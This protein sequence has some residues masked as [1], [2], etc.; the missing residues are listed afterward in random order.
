MPESL[1]IHQPVFINTIG[2]SAGALIFGFLL[3]LLLR[4]GRAPKFGLPAL[5]ALLALLWNAGSLVVL[6]STASGPGDPQAATALSFAALSMMPAV[7]LALSLG[8][9]GVIFQRI[10]WAVSAVA[11]GLHLAEAVLHSP[12][13]H[14]GA[15]LLIAAAFALLSVGAAVTGQDRRTRLLSRILTPMALLVFASSFVHFGESDGGHA[16]SEEIALHH[17]GIP[18]ALFIVLQQDYRF[19]LLDAFTRS[20]A[21][22]GLASAF[23]FAALEV[24]SRFG[25]LIQ[26]SRSPLIGGFA[27]VAACG[28]LVLFAW[29]RSALQL[30]LTARVFRRPVLEDAV[31]R[32]VSQVAPS[33]MELLESLAAVIAEH[34]G[35]GRFEIRPTSGSEWYFP[36]PVGRRRREGIPEWAEAAVPIRAS[37]GDEIHLILLGRR[38]GGRRYLSGDFS[39]LLQ[40]SLVATGRL[41]RFR[42]DEMERLATHAELRA[43]QAQINPHFLFNA[44]NALYGTIPR[45]EDAAR[46]T[47]LNLAEMFRFFLRTDRPLIPVSEEVRIIRAYLDIEQLRLGDRLRTL[48]EVDPD[49]ENVHIPA[50]SIEPLVE[51]AVRHGVSRKAGSGVV[52]VRIQKVGDDVLVQVEDTG[53]G[54]AATAGKGEGEGVGLDNVRQRLRLR[55][56]ASAEVRIESSPEGSV[57]SFTVP[58]DTRMGAER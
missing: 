54:F 20:L 17:A 11:V 16:W 46:R 48:V 22:A 10:G 57:V 49:A 39:D 51:N 56:G 38:G 4:D 3:V 41:E 35:T 52:S 55:Y 45:R 12:G 50:L 6:V 30:W 34:A 32:L 27:V 5:A 9:E 25:V 36:E 14:S 1:F 42:S 40:L 31:A 15:L 33:E 26:A 43:L 24:N 2:H 37:T 7:L 58:A 23:V 13:L 18:L 47:V 19:L 53:P 28:A 29:T 8:S 21:S 44:L